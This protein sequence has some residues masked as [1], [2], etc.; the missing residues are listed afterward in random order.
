[1]NV[2]QSAYVWSPALDWWRRF[3]L[4]CGK[5]QEVAVQLSGNEGGSESLVVPVDCLK[6]SAA[7]LFNEPARIG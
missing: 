1:M 6:Q 3:A 4:C 7:S 2:D 5:E